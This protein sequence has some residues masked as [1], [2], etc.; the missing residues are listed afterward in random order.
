MSS[1]NKVVVMG[2]LVRDPMIRTTAS[3]LNIA[4]FTLA[5]EDVFTNSKNEASKRTSFPTC[6]AWGKQTEKLAGLHKG[7]C[8][9]VIGRLVTGSYD[10]K[11]GVKHYTTDVVADKLIVL[12]L[13][14]VESAQPPQPAPVDM[15]SLRRECGFEESLSG[16]VEIPF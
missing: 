2:N 9:A 4:S 11:N 10:D 16:E 14:N 3:G 6:K 1:A 8:V 15:D 12:A 7:D 5:V 13:P